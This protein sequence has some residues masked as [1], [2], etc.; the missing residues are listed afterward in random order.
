MPDLFLLFNHTLT[1]MQQQ[2]AR[3]ELGVNRIVTPPADI[4]HLWAGIP[5][6]PDAIRDILQPIFS[7]IDQ[8]ASTGD[9]LLVQGDFGACWLVLEHIQSTGILPVYA[10]TDRKAVERKIDNNTVQLTHTFSHVRFRQYGQ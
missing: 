6:Q 8:Q 3:S 7:W 9:F 4:S 5:P 10:T 1:D 2:L